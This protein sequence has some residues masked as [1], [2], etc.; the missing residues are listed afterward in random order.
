MDKETLDAM[1]AVWGIGAPVASQEIERLK[2][3][4]SLKHGMYASI[5]LVCKGT[6]C[7][8]YDVCTVDAK[9]RVN[10]I[11]CPMEI[12]AIMNR[13]DSWCMHFEIQQEGQYISERDLVDASLIRDLVDNEI[14]TLR[15]D[16]KIAMSADFIQRSVAEID[17]KCNVYYEDV[18]HPAAE[19]K[20]SLQEKRY[21]IL[22]LLNSTRKD[23]ADL[24]K[25]KNSYGE[26]SQTILEKVKN[27]IP[28]ID[29]DDAVLEVEEE[30]ENINREGEV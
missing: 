14:Q 27:A 10:G 5:P 7:P 1:E 29:L 23:K 28:K 18:I 12:A 19:Y 2:T 9:L 8:Y 17:R 20:L 13:F 4:Y 6:D 11:R 24:L 25:Q 26:K 30:M 22:N 15:A 3:N 21:K 16:N